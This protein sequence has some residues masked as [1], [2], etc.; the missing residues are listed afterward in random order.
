ML[1]YTTIDRK[2]LDLSDLSE[3][4]RSFFE[5]CVK[6]YRSDSSYAIFVNAL[7][8]SSE[9]PLIHATGGWITR[10][11][12]DHPLYQ[13]VNDLSE[14]LGIRQRLLGANGN[15]DLVT[16]PLADEWLPTSEAAQR[17]GVSYSGLNQAIK[18]GDVLARPAKA[19]GSHLLVSAR[20][21]EQWTPMKVRQ[22]A[23][24]QVKR[25]KRGDDVA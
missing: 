13:A 18:R 11:V 25:R 21:L 7:M 4:E 12:N 22:A 3:G 15:E 10:A 9:N 17:K 23:G 20:S 24:G 14:R 6:H 5:R 1:S 19:G 8:N 2:V 16:D